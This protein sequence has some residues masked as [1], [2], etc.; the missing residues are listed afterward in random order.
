MQYPADKLMH[1][2]DDYIFSAVEVIMDVVILQCSALTMYHGQ[3]EDYPAWRKSWYT[4]WRW[5]RGSIDPGADQYRD[6]SIM[7]SML[8]CLQIKFHSSPS[9]KVTFSPLVTPVAKSSVLGTWPNVVWLWKSWL[10]RCW[11]NVVVM[12]VAGPTMKLKR[13][14]VTNMYEEEID[15][16]Y[17]EASGQWPQQV[18]CSTAAADAA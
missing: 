18:W 5:S 17:S 15:A 13:Q 8:I 14:V 4:Q 16:L 2:K 12:S 10:I 9:N 6:E 7:E 3:L 1:R 11:L